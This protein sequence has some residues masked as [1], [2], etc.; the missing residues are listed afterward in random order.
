MPTSHPDPV[1]PP[2]PR[3]SGAESP[4]GP[5][6]PR[7]GGAAPGGAAHPQKVGIP[8][9]QVRSRAGSGGTGVLSEY[10]AAAPALSPGPTAASF[11]RGWRGGEQS[12]A[13]L[14]V[15]HH[16]RFPFGSPP[17]A[18]Y[19]LQSSASSQKQTQTPNPPPA[20]AKS[21]LHRV[22][23]GSTDSLAAGPLTP[24]WGHVLPH[25]HHQL[26]LSARGVGD[27]RHSGCGAASQPLH[28]SP[29]PSHNSSAPH[30]RQGPPPVRFGDGAN[31]RVRHRT[32]KPCNPV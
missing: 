30:P 2:H 22:S 19:P 3:A 12:A 18:V 27:P 14:S 11:L 15:H 16:L 17:G 25:R 9:A 1:P 31:L 7:C 4:P 24:I 6:P 5:V 8:R 10:R 13:L 29:N 26:M 20:A 21:R 32:N 28:T 23:W